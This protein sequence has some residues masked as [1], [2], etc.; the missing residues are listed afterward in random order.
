VEV[1]IAGLLGGYAA[2]LV[3]P[4]GISWNVLL[5]FQATILTVG[6]FS[7]IF[8]G[9]VYALP[10]L[11]RE[12]RPT[13]F[14]AQLVSCTS[15][16]L[17]IPMLGGVVYTILAEIIVEQLNVPGGVAR[18]FWW[19]L[20]SLL[21]STCF[22]IL[23][24]SLKI[25]CRTMMGLIP[26]FLISG[27]VLDKVFLPHEE[28]LKGALFIGV[29][30]SVGYIIAW[31]LLKD[32][33]LD[34]EINSSVSFRYFIDSA[35][36]II[37]SSDTCDLSLDDGPAQILC[38]SCNDGIHALDVLGDENRIVVNSSRIRHRVLVDGD[39]ISI[40]SRRFTYHS[41]LARSR[42]IIPEAFA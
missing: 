31:E 21:I 23:N 17:A 34:E 40:G 15:V 32:A 8:T 24:H 20:L 11:S 29:I 36:F 38:I 2:W 12:R 30:I 19:L 25:M 3:S 41:K 7:G 28:Y 4:A 1:T 6:V 35:D 33:W 16:G 42:D 10:H 26:S 9:L 37:G 27:V 14:F 18:F 39:V 5:N 13:K 22:G